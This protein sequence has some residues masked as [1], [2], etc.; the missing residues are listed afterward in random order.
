MVYK[1]GSTKDRL[2][3]GNSTGL[4][5]HIPETPDQAKWGHML[6]Q[7]LTGSNVLLPQIRRKFFVKRHPGCRSPRVY[8]QDLV[9]LADLDAF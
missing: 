1:S 2:E 9:V 8:M 4:K 6:A 7:H 3:G 5:S